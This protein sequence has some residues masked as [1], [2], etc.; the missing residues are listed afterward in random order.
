MKKAVKNS[1]VPCG[2]GVMMTVETR[3]NY[4]A[5]EHFRGRSRTQ[6]RESSVASCSRGHLANPSISS[7]SDFII[8]GHSELGSRISNSEHDQILGTR[9]LHLE[10]PFSTTQIYKKNSL[11]LLS[12]YA[13]QNVKCNFTEN[14]GFIQF[15]IETYLEFVRKSK[16]TEE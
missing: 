9:R 4:A 13:F 3:S 14:R 15:L 7:A 12:T 5:S 8:E 2:L 16:R 11:N 6:F 1:D 10:T